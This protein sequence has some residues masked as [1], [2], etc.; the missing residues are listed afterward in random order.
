MPAVPEVSDSVVISAPPDK[1]FDAISH[2]ERMGEFSPEC[3]GGRWLGGASGP[4]AGAKF[5][6]TNS[7]GTKQ[8]STMARVVT[9]SPPTAFAF[10][11]TVGPAKVARWSYALEPSGAGT[12]VT[13]S[14]TD[15]RSALSKRL[16]RS[17]RPDREAFTRQSIR[18]T[19]D[20]LKSKLEG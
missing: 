14:W 19:L 6:G 18:T 8:W 17:I 2:L 10:D 16:T 7:N 11:V 1:V 4:A 3:T 5:R 13:E 15:Q 9:Y 20:Q 12:K